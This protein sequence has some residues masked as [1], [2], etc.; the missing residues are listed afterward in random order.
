MLVAERTSIGAG[1]VPVPVML[2]ACGL[3]VASSVT[4]NV[5]VRVPAAAGEKVTLMVQLWPAGRLGPQLLISAKSLAFVPVNPMLV[6]FSG[7]VWLLFKVTTWA[8]LVV[9]V[10][11]ALK[12]RLA[13]E[14]VTV[15]QVGIL[16]LETR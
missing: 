11:C 5:A 6:M 3:P 2:T 16:K 12:V 15:P 10:D 14:T 8:G 1:V 7:T 13:G 9:P 4:F